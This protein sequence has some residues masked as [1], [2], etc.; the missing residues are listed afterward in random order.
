MN[1]PYLID[2]EVSNVLG[3]LVRNARVPLVQGRA[4]VEALTLLPLERLDHRSFLPRLWE[5]R[6]NLS[7]YDASYVAF[8]ES[9]DAPLITIDAGIATAPNHRAKVELFARQM[10]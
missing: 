1:A 8:A 2:L 7:S 9:L 5:L 4:V 6:D 10:I 3:K